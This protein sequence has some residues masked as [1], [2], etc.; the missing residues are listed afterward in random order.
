MVSSVPDGVVD[1]GVEEVDGAVV[2]VLVVVDVE[3]VGGATEVVV[4]GCVD[5]VDEVV[6]VSSGPVV[7]GTDES[8]LPPVPQ[9]TSA[10]T[11]MATSRRFMDSPLWVRV[12][13][14]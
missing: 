5:V 3:V 14:L 12:R 2:V 7:A 10:R 4:V 13:P 11:T 6:D 8:A 1:E 9:A